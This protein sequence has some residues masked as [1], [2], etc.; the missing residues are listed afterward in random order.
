MKAAVIRE[1]GEPGVIAIEQVADPEA[2][3]GEVVVDLRAAAL[4][5]LDIWV[6]RGGRV[7]LEWPHLIGSDGAGVVSALGKSVHGVQVGQEVIVNPGLSCGCCEFCRGGEQSLCSDF[8]IVGM[9]RPGTFAEKVAVPARCVAPKPAH[10]SF[11]ESGGLGIAYTTAWRTLMTR[12]R[13][14]PGEAVLI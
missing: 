3:P 14:R 10:L 4:N 11:E 8:G 1:H 12:A 5:H 2:R 7:A 13:A 6:R 9:G